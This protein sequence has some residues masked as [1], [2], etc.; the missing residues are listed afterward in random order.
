MPRAKVKTDA[1]HFKVVPLTRKLKQWGF[2]NFHLSFWKLQITPGS[3]TFNPVLGELC[4]VHIKVSADWISWSRYK[5]PYQD[6]ITYF[7]VWSSNYFLYLVGIPNWRN[8]SYNTY[9][10]VW[11]HNTEWNTHKEVFFIH[12]TLHKSELVNCLIQALSMICFFLQ[13]NNTSFEK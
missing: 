7:T 13:N 8:H 2:V 4:F 5:F 12:W 3:S 11:M 6:D 1:G 10:H 9:T